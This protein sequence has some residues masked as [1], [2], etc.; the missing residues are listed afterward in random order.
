MFKDNLGHPI[1]QNPNIKY[2]SWINFTV[3]AKD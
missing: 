2:F 1:I 3:Q